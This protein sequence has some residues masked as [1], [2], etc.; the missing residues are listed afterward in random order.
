MHP[1]LVETEKSVGGLAKGFTDNYI[2]VHFEAKQDNANR[3]VQVKLD[4]L[5][6]RFVV[7]I[8]V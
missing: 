8:L 5:Q 2:P 6:E 3:V 7:G 4:R 1:V